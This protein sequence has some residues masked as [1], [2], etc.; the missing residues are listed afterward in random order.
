MLAQNTEKGGATSG[1]L[2]YYR[3]RRTCAKASS[4]EFTPAANATRDPFGAV[5][6]DAHG[7]GAGD[8]ARKVA[9]VGQP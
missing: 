6:L 7:L 9:G 2:V 5:V 3:E 8:R 4:A 1:M